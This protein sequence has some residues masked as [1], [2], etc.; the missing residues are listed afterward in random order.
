MQQKKNHRMVER[1][2]VNV[3]KSWN[4]GN[5]TEI[6]CYMYLRNIRIGL[7]T[8]LTLVSLMIVSSSLLTMHISLFT[9]AIT[10]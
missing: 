3:K 4:E 9:Y 1:F 6:A 7:I 10:Y 2:H 5:G 8:I